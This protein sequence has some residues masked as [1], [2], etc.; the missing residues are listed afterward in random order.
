MRIDF[1]KTAGDYATHRAGFP[2]AFFARLAT[3]GVGL[4]G[5]RVLDVGTGTGTLARGFAQR[6]C[7]AIGI[8]PSAA[9]LDAA[10][11]LDADAGV[12]VDYRVGRAE[13]TGL[14]AGSVDVVTAGQCWHWFD[15]PRAAAEARRVL[16]AD[17]TL[18]IGHFDWIP[19]PGNVVEATERLILRHNPAWTF[20][21]S[22]GLYPLWLEDVAGAGFHDLETF[23][24][25]VM[26]PY[27]HEGWRGRIRASAGVA[28]SLPPDAVA[29]FDDEL[30]TLLATSFPASPMG[31]HHRVFGLVCRA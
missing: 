26:A 4:D 20:F 25:D 15:R 1:G 12:T 28:A 8:D 27:T 5:Q 29:R 7:R 10:R 22:T 11:G 14:A 3:F 16:T 17:G 18:V 13:D 6:G 23:S 19:L 30:A 2:D 21:G 9:M 24:F 31:V